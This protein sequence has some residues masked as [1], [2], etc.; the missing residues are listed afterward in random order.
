LSGA[1]PVALGQ[2]CIYNLGGSGIDNR[3]EQHAVLGQRFAPSPIGPHHQQFS[4]L[5]ML[6]ER[7]NRNIASERIDC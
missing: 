3:S 6:V 5:N 2:G 4:L 7:E 1:Q